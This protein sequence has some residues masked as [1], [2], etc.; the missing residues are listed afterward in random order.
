MSSE[1]SRQRSR[2]VAFR[3]W[4]RMLA[5]SLAI[6]F[7]VGVGGGWAVNASL[8][9]AIVAPGFVVVERNVK[10]VQHLDGG[11]VAEIAVRDGDHVEAGQIVM[12]LDVSITKAELGVV[13][14]QL[15]ELSGRKIRLAAERDGLESIEVPAEFVAMGPL[16]DAVLQG[17]TRLFNENRKTRESQ[18][19]Q[20]KLRIRQ[21]EEEVRG[22]TAQADAKKVE[23]EIIGKELVQVRELHRQNLTPITRVYAMERDAA[24]LSG[25]RGH[26]IAQMARAA[27]QVSEIQLQIISIDQNVRT[28]AQRELRTIEGRIGEL[29][30]RQTAARDRLRR[31]DIR[32]PQAGVV[33]ELSVHTV[34]GIV[35]PASTIMMIVPDD[36]RLSVEARIAPFDIDQVKVGQETRLRFTAFSR[37]MTPEIPARITHVAAN[38]SQDVKSGGSYYVVRAD[39][40]RAASSKLA[41]LELVPGMP[42][43]VFIATSQ[44]T[45]LSYFMKPLTDQFMRAFREE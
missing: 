40:D 9:G 32:A 7:M 33:H 29:L 20:L 43:E 26:L 18:K 10:K 24:R 25:D 30:E 37:T 6:L 38:I 31:M 42:V 34:G 41:G 8:S 12:R 35:T 2:K 1:N 17:E 39:V 23:I 36:E 21:L 4:P 27:G 14:T 44:R 28:E 5:A 45:P 19:E 22:L 11:I 3:V 16:A 13:E 15:I